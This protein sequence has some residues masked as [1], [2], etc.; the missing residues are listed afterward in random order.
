M[1]SLARPT[2][3]LGTT[4]LALSAVWASSV[5]S[6]PPATP[7]PGQH[8][9]DALPT[10]A[11]S[12]TELATHDA[13]T[14]LDG[15]VPYMLERNDVAGAVVVVVKDGEIIVQKGYGLADVAARTPVDPTHTL[16]RPG[17]VTKLVT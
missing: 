15:L 10:V 1:Q 8:G 14:W 4:L 12:R 5:W 11:A 7:P 13:T 6:K 3:G 17:S 16:F 2:M 9:T